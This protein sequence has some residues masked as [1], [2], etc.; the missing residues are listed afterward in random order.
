VGS[1]VILSGPVAAGKTAVARELIKSSPDAFAH[2]EG[3]AFWSFI[4]K[5]PQT[6]GLPKRMVMIMRAMLA[7]ARHIERDGYEVIVDFTIPPWFLDGARAAQGK[8]VRLCRLTAERGSLRGAG[9]SAKRRH[10]SDAAVLA[11]RIR[12]GIDA[13]TFRVT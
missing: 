1:I 6:Q 3:D 9:G 7:A 2:I 12:E 4:I 10:E 5:S 11:G 8:A 13:G